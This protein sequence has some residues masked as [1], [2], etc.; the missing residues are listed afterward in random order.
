[1]VRLKEWGLPSSLSWS[2]DCFLR[3]DDDA[4]CGRENQQ[5]GDVSR[6]KDREDHV[7]TDR[8]GLASPKALPTSRIK[9]GEI[10]LYESSN[11]YRTFFDCVLSCKVTAA[12]AEVAH[13]SVTIC[14][15]GNIAMQLR[16]EK[17]RWEL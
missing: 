14:H 11:G 15:L 1:M 4:V 2:D 13:H 12:P 17:L 16:R 10:D 7:W 3:L 8:S 6:V 5:L 9:T